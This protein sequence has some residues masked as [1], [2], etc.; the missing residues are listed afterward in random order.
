MDEGAF[1]SC[2]DL[3]SYF[4]RNALAQAD[5]WATDNLA[6]YN[7][8]KDQVGYFQDCPK[9]YAELGELLNGKKTGRESDQEKTFAA[10]IGLAMEDMAVCP[11]L[12]NLA[13]EKNIGTWLPL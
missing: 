11:L 5:K 9:I 6:Q 10:N 8:F 3:G 4:S 12:Y 13:K 7:H 2:V 1:V